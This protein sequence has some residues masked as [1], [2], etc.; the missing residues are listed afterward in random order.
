MQ[1][2]QADVRWL[3]G[4]QKQRLSDEPVE[5]VGVLLNDR[6]QIDLFV[7]GQQ[8]SVRARRFRSILQVFILGDVHQFDLRGV[9]ERGGETIDEDEENE[10]E[11]VLVAGASSDETAQVN[12]SAVAVV[13]QVRGLTDSIVVQ[14]GQRVEEELI[15]M[16]VRRLIPLSSVSDEDRFEEVG[17]D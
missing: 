13:V 1:M 9:L 5:T 6:R 17:H 11:Y 16:I 7:D 12:Q 4:V 2:A 10:D 14:Q 8:I 3:F 15:E